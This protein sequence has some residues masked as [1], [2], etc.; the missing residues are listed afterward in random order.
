MLPRPWNSKVS[1][2]FTDTPFISL[3]V[4]SV[5]RHDSNSGMKSVLENTRNWSVAR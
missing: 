4:E 5:L 2:F 1:E 3:V